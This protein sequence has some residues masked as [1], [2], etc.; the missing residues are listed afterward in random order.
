MKTGHLFWHCFIYFS[1]N[2]QAFQGSVLLNSQILSAEGS[3]QVTTGNEKDLFILSTGKTTPEVPC[4]HL[5]SP[6]PGKKGA[7]TIQLEE[8]LWEILAVCMNT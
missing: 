7:G 3:C 8:D 6:I 4:L 1:A 2:H 5:G